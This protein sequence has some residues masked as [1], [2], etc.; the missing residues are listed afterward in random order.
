[1]KNKA[2]ALVEILVVCTI[3]IV[4]AGI[5]YPVLASATKRSRLS[6]SLL[7]ER[8]IWTAIQ[9]YRNDQESAS[10][11]GTPSQMG[12]PYPGETET[13]LFQYR[14]NQYG[15]KFDLSSSAV[16]SG[17]IG[18]CGTFKNKQWILPVVSDDHRWLQEVTVYGENKILLIDFSCSS[19]KD[20]LTNPY[21]EHEG[22]GMLLSGKGIIRRKTGNPGQSS[23]WGNP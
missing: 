14:L 7:R 10:E 18:G 3:L 9:L 16:S 17:W 1:M 22:T 8:Q 5:A 21:F 2:I 15:I 11:I 4:L 20:V 13:T 19:T 6:D 23:W 12:L